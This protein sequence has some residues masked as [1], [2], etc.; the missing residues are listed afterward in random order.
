M[1]LKQTFTSYS[2]DEFFPI[3]QD[4][5]LA[6]KTEFVAYKAEQFAGVLGHIASRT[7][8]A[9]RIAGSVLLEHI[10]QGGEL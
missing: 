4:G 9:T 2:P 3:Y 1:T 10:D 7:W 6:N 5:E 8:E